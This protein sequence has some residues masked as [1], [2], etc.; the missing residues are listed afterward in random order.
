MCLDYDLCDECYK[1]RLVY[2]DTEHEFDH[3]TEDLPMPEKKPL[4]EEEK[5]AAKERMKQRLAQIRKQK[6]DDE[7]ARDREREIMRRKGGK[8]S[9]EAKQ[10]WEENQHKLAA[11]KKQIEHEDTIKAKQKVRDRIAAQKAARKLAGKN[12]TNTTNTT[13]ITNTTNNTNTTNTT[14]TTNNA[15]EVKEYKECVVQVKL[16]NGKTIK[17]NFKPDDKLR[18]VYNWV[19]SNRADGGFGQFSLM[20]PYPP[21]REFGISSLDTVTLKDA[22]LVP[23]GSLILK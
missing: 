6:E 20:L 1:M 18:V 11:H 19:S 14:N 23:R 7:Q 4:T 16:K 13:N 10:K 2:H 9:Q 17:G 3:H 21:R 15:K 12:T 22:E 8:E 5:I